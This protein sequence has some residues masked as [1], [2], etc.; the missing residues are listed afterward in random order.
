MATPAIPLLSPDGAYVLTGDLL[1]N[2]NSLP[3]EPL[4]SMGGAGGEFFWS[5]DSKWLAFEVASQLRKVRVPD[6]APEVVAQLPGLNRGGTWNQDGT[7]LIAAAE[8]GVWGLYV[9]AAGGAL[10][11]VAAPGL[12]DGRYFLPEFLPNGSDF[13]FAFRPR[14]ATEAEIFL[15]TLR[16]GE[17]TNPVRLMQNPTAAHYTPAGG[18]RILFAR[19]DNL[20]SQRLSLRERRLAG[21]P[22]LIE[23]G[24][25]SAPGE[26]LADFSVSRSGLVAW[27]PGTQALSQVTVFDRQGRRVG[28]FGPPNDFNY[29]RLSPDETHLLGDVLGGPSQLME[30]DQ[31]G[32]LGLGQIEWKVWSPDGSHLLGRQGSRVVERTVGG[33]DE[34]RALADAPAI[35]FL[36]DI[37]PD[38]KIA[39]YSSNTAGERSVFSVRLDETQ[40]GKT[41]PVVKTGEQI[42]NARFSPDGRWIVYDARR[43]DKT[44]GIF[45]QPFPG[46]GLRKQISSSGVYPVWRKDAREIV[47]LDGKS[48]QISAI[49]VSGLSGDLRFGSPTPLFAMPPMTNLVVGANPL[50]ITRDGSLIIF[51]QALEQ[52]EV[53]NVIHVKSGW[54]QT[55][56]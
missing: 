14:G 37:S 3:M 43:Q 10:T 32:L 23:K 19:N 5:A 26:A 20:Y 25:A 16:H 21:D 28:A 38:G 51:P 45:V 30:R 41:S 34:I 36:E 47:Y 27:R 53:S 24:V 31:P 29:L 7:M 9:L 33:S 2:L 40:A 17:V 35:N 42:L 39:L 1:R 54:G 4:R 6:G 18:G 11:K 49:P 52:P 22:E 46:P 15:A 8:S 50:A 55:P 48:R 44:L 56:R 12:Q 13:L